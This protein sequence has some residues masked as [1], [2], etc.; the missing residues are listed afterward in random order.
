MASYLRSALRSVWVLFPLA[1]AHGIESEL[2]L[3]GDGVGGGGAMA[4]PVTS[5]TG[6][7][8]SGAGGT[9]GGAAGSTSTGDGTGG[10]TGG[11]G[12]NATMTVGVGGNAGA[13]TTG[14]GGGAGGATSG[15]GGTGGSAGAGGSGGAGGAAGAGGKG[16]SGGTGGASGSGGKAGGNVDAG[17]PPLKPTAIT[18]GTSMATSLEAPSTGTAFSER[19]RT[20][21]VLIGY[22][23][24][25]DP[26]TSQ[27]NYLRNFEAVCGTLSIT[28]TT[29]YRVATTQAEALT[30]QGTDTGSIIQTALCPTNQVVVGFGGRD[31]SFIDALTFSCAP[32]TISGTSPNFTLSIGAATDTSAIGGPGGLPFTAVECPANT[33]AVGHAGRADGDIEGF[34]LLCARPTLVVR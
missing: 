19:C 14:G 31:G 23:G 34:G 32:L 28:G 8:S 18:L 3:A 10:A 12:G 29:T 7:A 24:T 11:A 5:G 2:D 6:G 16:G 17:P 26:P 22:R 21:E 27:I 1:C 25:V 33:I 13:A 4:G 20:N 15:A 30:T 9:H